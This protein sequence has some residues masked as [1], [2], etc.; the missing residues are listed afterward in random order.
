MNNFNTFN[1]IQVEEILK[2]IERDPQ[3]TLQVLRQ[4]AQDM[5]DV[6]LSIGAL[7]NYLQGNFITLKKFIMSQLA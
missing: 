7:F 2:V 5:F 3:Q 6:T 1:Y 4:K